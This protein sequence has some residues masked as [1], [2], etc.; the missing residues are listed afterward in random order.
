MRESERGGWRGRERDTGMRWRE[1]DEMERAR[2]RE[3]GR[4]RDWVAVKELR[5]SYQYS[6]LI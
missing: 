4:E 1:Q 5:L 3:P 6:N 2:E